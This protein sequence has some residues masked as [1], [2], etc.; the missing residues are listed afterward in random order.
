MT[1]LPM[2]KQ[3]VKLTKVAN[4]EEDT[5]YLK[6]LL[7]FRRVMTIVKGIWVPGKVIIHS[8]SEGEGLLL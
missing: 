4:S 7:H 6:K 2:Y 5:T 3:K 8:L 1:I